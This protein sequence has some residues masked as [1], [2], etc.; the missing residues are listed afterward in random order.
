[1]YLSVNKENT[2]PQQNVKKPLTERVGDW[3]CGNCKNLNFSFRKVCNR[4]QITRVQSGKVE[5]DMI[6]FLAKSQQ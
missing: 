4:C 1:M 2:N 5:E 6:H 3:V